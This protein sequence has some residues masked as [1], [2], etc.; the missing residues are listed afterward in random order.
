M[1]FFQ[2]PQF[3]VTSKVQ[4]DRRTP[5]TRITASEDIMIALT[6]AKGGMFGGNP[7]TVLDSPVDIVMHS[8]HFTNFMQDYEEA[9]IQLNKES[10]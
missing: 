3:R 8:Y 5:S 7:Q 2:E 1:P 4:S 9:S 10:K 6:L